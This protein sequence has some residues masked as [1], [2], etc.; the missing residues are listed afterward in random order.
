MFG[1]V[2]INSELLQLELCQNIWLYESVTKLTLILI[3]LW[4]LLFHECINFCTFNSKTPAENIQ[5][6][7]RYKF[8]YNYQKT[9]LNG[10]VEV[11]NELSNI[12]NLEQ[13]YNLKNKEVQSLTTAIDVTNELFKSSR[14]DYFEVLMTQRDALESKLELIEAKKEQFNA[15]TNVYRA[16]GGGWN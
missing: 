15:V 13:F 10:Y 4:T 1:S 14:V 16:L 2:C 11:S 3:D 7:I 6:N 8:N 9:I 12:K 5:A